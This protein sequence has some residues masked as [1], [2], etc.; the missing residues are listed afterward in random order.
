MWISGIFL[1]FFAISLLRLYYL[2]NGERSDDY[3]VLAIILASF[4]LYQKRLTN[5]IK[6][7]SLSPKGD[8]LNMKIYGLLAK[9]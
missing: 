9:S 1:A 6:S 3:I 4:A 8:R 2:Q 7:I 5:T